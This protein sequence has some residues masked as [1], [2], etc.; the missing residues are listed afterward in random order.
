VVKRLNI[1]SNPR[2]VRRRIEWTVAV[3]FVVAVVLIVPIVTFDGLRGPQTEVPAQMESVAVEIFDLGVTYQLEDTRIFALSSSR[4]GI[5]DRV[6]PAGILPDDTLEAFLLDAEGGFIV[7]DRPTETVP[8][9]RVRLFGPQAAPVSEFLIPSG[10]ALF[11]SALDGGLWVGFAVG[12]T[13]T[14]LVR[15]YSPEGDLLGEY[16]LPAGVL[17]RSLSVA[18]TGE[19]WVQVEESE[20]EMETYAATYRSYLLPVAVGEDLAPALDPAAG[21]IEGNFIGFDGRLYS[22]SMESIPQGEEAN[23]YASVL[24]ALASDGSRTTF[25]VPPGYRPFAADLDGRVY[26]EE[27]AIDR[28]PDRYRGSV[29]EG[30]FGVTELLVLD[31]NGMYARV[32]VEARSGTNA[33]L[34]IVQTSDDGRIL[35]VLRE[36]ESIRFST[37]APHPDESRSLADA[38]L[39]DAEIGLVGGPMLLSGDPYRALDD[40]QRNYM[41]LI[42]A[43]LTRYDDSL[44]AVPDMAVSVPEPGA[45]VSDDGLTITY[46]LRGDL[47]WHDDVPVTGED[48]VA[49]WRYLSAPSVIPRGRPFPGFDHIESVSASGQIVTV[50]LSVPFGAGPESFFPFVLPAHLLDSSVPSLNAGFWSAPIGCGPYRLT[51]WTADGLWQLEAHDDSPRGPVSVGTIRVRFEESEEALLALQTAPVPTV[52]SWVDPFMLADLRRDAVG[53]LERWPTGRWFGLI[54]N[55]DAS[56]LADPRVRRAL[57]ESFPIQ[58]LEKNVWDMRDDDRAPSLF[59]VPGIA[60]PS[61]DA[62]D[63]SVGV[64]TS[65]TFDYAGGL[66]FGWPETAYLQLETVEKAWAD[67][68]LQVD[69]S[70]GRTDFYVAWIMNGFLARREFEIAEGVFPA[71]PDAGWGGVFDS[72]DI[73]SRQNPSGVGVGALDDATLRQL[74]EQAKAEYDD[75]RRKELSAQI[76]DRLVELSAFMFERAEYRYSARVGD[77]DGFAPAPYP[78]GDFWNIESWSVSGRDSK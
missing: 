48:V 70:A 68:G 58:E 5:A 57:I 42:Y 43:G 24:T 2:D 20:V 32:P 14:E 61:G 9:G 23:E 73:P 26:C 45:G 37:L 19:L 78:A 71:Y 66:R 39:R 27:L 54:F 4:E 49:T 53:Q 15:R 3:L 28:T 63:A 33:L 44:T 34:P 25:D 7:V 36:G 65:T 29:G 30:S 21:A 18:P 10:A 59:S 6:D 62:V 38:D 67:A 13:G 17:A 31:R 72:F 60:M 8:A 55:D 64:G 11:S 40:M 56:T 75:D 22:L 76:A 74:F 52:W 12:K 16:P 35:T 1:S 50:N 51:R 77:I 41:S 69:R 47:R 46:E